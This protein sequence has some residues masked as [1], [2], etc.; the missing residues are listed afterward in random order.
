MNVSRILNKSIS[1]VTP[2]MHGRRRKSLIAGIGSLL[3]GSAATVTSLGRGTHSH[4]KERHKIKRADR[5]L[6]NS[7]LQ[8]ESVS[9]YQELAKQT[10]SI[11]SQFY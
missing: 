8:Q 4:A 3:A 11:S 10:S 1:I 6:S 2:S 7:I 5:L 9:I